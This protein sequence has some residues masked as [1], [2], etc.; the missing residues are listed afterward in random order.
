MS[1]QQ[2]GRARIDPAVV[3]DAATTLPATREAGEV[4]AR[5]RRP[6]A[7]P[8]DRPR[9]LTVFTTVFFLYLFAP[10][11]VVF[12]FSFNSKR[13]TQVFGQLSLTWYQRL[14]NDSSMLT[15]MRVSIE[16]AF[17]TMIAATA[18]GTMLAFGLVRARSRL[19][20]P[21]DVT[22]LLNLISPE[23]VTAIA[24][25]LVFSELGTLLTPLG[26]TFHLSL[27]TVALGH[28]T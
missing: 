22:M 7:R 24:L 8:F 1:E 3:G 27:V 10:I 6:G 19:T 2:I 5:R 12:L 21:T 15:S 28:I 26:V 20:R 9:F 25:L 16:I 11:L 17:V 4:G 23:I 13:S 14:L 18:L